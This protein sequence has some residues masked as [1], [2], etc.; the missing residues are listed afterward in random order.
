MAMSLRKMPS[1][2]R[3]RKNLKTRK[4]RPTL[5][6]GISV[7]WTLL[8]SPIYAQT[9]VAIF[10]SIISSIIDRKQTVEPRN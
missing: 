4:R 10:R 3:G 9:G 1:E 2:K 5:Y 6:P 7:V 8:R